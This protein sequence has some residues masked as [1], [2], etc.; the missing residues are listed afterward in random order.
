[1]AVVGITHS[2]EKSFAAD[3]RKTF[4]LFRVHSRLNFDLRSSAQIRG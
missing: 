1:V 3:L 2:L 4:A